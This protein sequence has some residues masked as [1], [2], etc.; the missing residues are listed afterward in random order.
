MSSPLLMAT[1][2]LY[3]LSFGAVLFNQG[4]HPNHIKA[5]GVCRAIEPDDFTHHIT[6]WNTEQFRKVF[7]SK[8]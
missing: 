7:F 8:P 6:V 4:A 1:G 5:I 2:N 3:A